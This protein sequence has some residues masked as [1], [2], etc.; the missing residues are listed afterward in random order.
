[1]PIVRV[2][3]DQEKVNPADAR[4]LSEAIQKIVAEV[5]EIEDVIVYANDSQIKV[6]AWPVEVFVQMN[7]SLIKEEDKLFE[8]LKSRII[9]WKKES[10][11]PH[12]INL[13]F[14]PMKWRIEVGL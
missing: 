13:T 2:D 12:P 6:K 1:M 10:N 14:I 3:F 11:F 5:T 8:S 9:A 4:A 7:V